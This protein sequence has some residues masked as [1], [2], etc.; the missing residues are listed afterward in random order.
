M[1]IE[2]ERERERDIELGSREWGEKGERDWGEW[3]KKKR[4]KVS[5]EKK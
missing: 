5:R 4:D 1:G 2:R 3:E